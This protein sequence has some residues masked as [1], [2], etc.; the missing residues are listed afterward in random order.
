MKYYAFVTY[1]V[2]C[3]RSRIV[4]MWPGNIPIDKSQNP[5]V[6]W[7][8]FTISENQFWAWIRENAY[9]RYRGN[10]HYGI[11][12][13]GIAEE[14]SLDCEQLMPLYLTPNRHQRKHLQELSKY[15][16]ANYISEN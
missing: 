15:I 3:W 16:S 11:R 10:R 4:T 6:K 14:H 5:D 13:S 12:I 7:A 2:G 1:A 8:Y 9:L